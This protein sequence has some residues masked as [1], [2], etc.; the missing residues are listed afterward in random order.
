M[1]RFIGSLLLLNIAFLLLWGCGKKVSEKQYFDLA[2]KYMENQE[3]SKAEVNFQKVLDEYPNGVYSSKA[4]FMLG[5]INA[6][7]L[8]NYDKAKEYY[9]E[10][11]KKYPNHELADDARYELQNLGK[12]TDDLPFLKDDQSTADTTKNVQTSAVK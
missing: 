4:L 10:F 6:N 7:D 5:F 11:L 2:H 12:N 8:K 3:W 9:T 1:K